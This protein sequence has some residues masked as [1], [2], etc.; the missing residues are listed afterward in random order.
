LQL[1]L[2][3]LFLLI[4]S[5]GCAGSKIEK[6]T[7]VPGSSGSASWVSNFN[8]MSELCNSSDVI[9]VGTVD[10]V[11]EVVPDKN[12]RGMLYNATS[13]FRIEKVLKGK[14]GKEIMLT[15]IAR[16]DANGWVEGKAEDPP[17]E[18]GEKWV[19]F[20]NADMSYQ[21]LGPWGR[22]KIIDDKIYSM[23]RVIGND[24]GYYE[25]KLDFNGMGLSE[26]IGSVNETLDSVV[27]TFTDSR[28]NWAIESAV[29]F[30]AGGLQEVNVNLS[31][32]KYG[33]ADIMY[34]VEMVESKDSAIGIS[35][36]AGIEITV[37][38]SQFTAYP[39]N[40][41][42]SSIKI[43]TQPDIPP[44]TYWIRVE[45]RFGETLSGQ[46]MLMVNIDPTA[47]AVTN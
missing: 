23:N 24:I 47:T 39:R 40:E 19:L 17:F 22:Y 21:N 4:F 29:R 3:S 20:L 32:G 26:F 42:K 34:S 36:P 45:Y 12:S 33:P 15:K 6:V 35:M 43:L 13:A 30:D 38:P 1:I 41:Y 10:R 5:S 27:F 25:E 37:E 18:A 46:R 11:I 28:I 9:V 7:F 2:V 31:T 8:D 44:G 16:A 14:I